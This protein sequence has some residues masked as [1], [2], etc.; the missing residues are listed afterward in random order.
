MEVSRRKTEEGSYPLGET[1]E[2]ED[3]SQDILNS[4]RKE[5]LSDSDSKALIGKRSEQTRFC[6]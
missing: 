3:Q 5:E 4:I 6:Y 2:Y 1:D